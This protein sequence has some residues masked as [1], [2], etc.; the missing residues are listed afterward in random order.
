MLLLFMFSFTIGV[1]HT[2]NVLLNC[3]LTTHWKIKS[4]GK[5]YL[6]ISFLYFIFIFIEIPY[7][8]QNSPNV[9]IFALKYLCSFLVSF[10]FNIYKNT[11][12]GYPFIFKACIISNYYTCDHVSMYR[13]PCHKIVSLSIFTFTKKTRYFC[14]NN[15]MLALCNNYVISLTLNYVMILFQYNIIHLHIAFN[16]MVMIIIRHIHYINSV[17]ACILSKHGKQCILNT[18]NYICT[19]I[20]CIQ[21]ICNIFIKHVFLYYY[22]LYLYVLSYLSLFVIALYGYFM[23]ACNIIELLCL[24]IQSAC[25]LNHDMCELNIKYFSGRTH[26]ACPCSPISLIVRTL[27]MYRHDLRLCLIEYK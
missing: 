15:T 24:V 21:T 23:Y 10:T 22:C 26:Y 16:V 25:L 6:I 27:T 20:T 19:I 11:T 3:K 5:T 17:Y 1:T 8:F 9:N 7:N 13:F 12:T 18:N 14:T 2:A 4:Y